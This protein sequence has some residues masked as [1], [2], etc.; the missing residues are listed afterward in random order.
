MAV[1]KTY[2]S[3]C[4]KVLTKHQVK[5]GVVIGNKDDGKIAKKHSAEKHNGASIY[6]VMEKKDVLR[7]SKKKVSKRK[8]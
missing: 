2:C 8:K 6:F 1:K 4:G 5:N 3:L 7:S